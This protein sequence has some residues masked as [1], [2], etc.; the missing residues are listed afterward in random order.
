MVPCFH[1]PTD[2]KTL[3][4]A[5]W[6]HFHVP[7]WSRPFMRL[8]PAVPRSCLFE[9]I[10]KIC[11]VHID[12][13]TCTVLFFMSLVEPVC[14]SNGFLYEFKSLSHIFTA[15]IQLIEVC[16]CVYARLLSGSELLQPQLLFFCCWR[17]AAVLGSS[18]C[19]GPSFSWGTDGLTISIC[20]PRDCK[21]SPNPPPLCWGVCA[22]STLVLSVISPEVL[23]L[24]QMQLSNLSCAFQSFF[25]MNFNL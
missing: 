21:T 22:L 18:S 2:T 6:G 16:R 14:R 11:R 7:V 5:S 23:W 25:P 19:C 15:L 17:S 13:I 4:S 8:G 10:W 1:E 9:K 3:R 20:P 12:I 24:L